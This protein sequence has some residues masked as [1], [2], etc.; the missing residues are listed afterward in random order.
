[1]PFY[2]DV[3]YRVYQEALTN[4]LRHGKA[5]NVSIIIRLS[6]H[7]IATSILDDGC[8]CDTLQKGLGLT[9]MEQRVK[10]VIRPLAPETACLHA[11]GEAP[12]SEVNWMNGGF[13]DWILDCNERS[14][15]A[16]LESLRAEAGS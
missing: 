3:V 5:Q 16:G 11:E 12:C 9:S 7:R 15:G 6:N 10:S 8:G 14:L 13:C 4:S 2:F 1:M